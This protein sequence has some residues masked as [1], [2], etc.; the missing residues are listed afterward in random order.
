MNQ[1]RDTTYQNDGTGDEL[2]ARAYTAEC[3]R[4]AKAHLAGI[5]GGLKGALDDYRA[6]M[7]VDNACGIGDS[8]TLPD[9]IQLSDV[10][11]EVRLALLE[12]LTV[13]SLERGK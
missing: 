9:G 13:Q 8:W 10:L 1:V 2:K 12:A 6:G 5:E 4:I 11:D 3:R 7:D